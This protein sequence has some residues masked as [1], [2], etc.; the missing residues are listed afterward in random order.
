[1]EQEINT[2]SQKSFIKRFWWL[3]PII[4]V[5][6]IAAVIFLS[7]KIK[8]DGGSNSKFFLDISQKVSALDSR[9]VDTFAV[10]SGSAFQ[11]NSP[12][13]VDDYIYIGS[14]RRVPADT[15]PE[16]LQGL[17]HQDYFYK[18]DLD[19]NEIWE[20]ALPEYTMCGGGAALDSDG[21]IYFVATR[22]YPDTRP[23]NEKS[24]SKGIL[25]ENWIYS[26]TNSG[27]FRW[28]KL[29]SYPNEAWL[30]AMF[31]VSISDTDTIYVADSKLFAFNQN[32]ETNWQYPDDNRTI[33]GNRSAAIIDD[34]GYIYFIS[35]DA[36]ENYYETDDIRLFKFAPN[37]NGTPIYSVTLD[38]NIMVESNGMGGGYKDRWQLSTPAFSTNKKTI[39]A[40]VGNTMNAINTSDGEILWSYMPEGI[41][42]TFKASP[43][44][45]ADNNIYV[46]TKDNEGSVFYAFKSDGSGLLW[47]KATSADLYVSP[48]IGDDNTIY[49]GSETSPDGQF[50]AIDMT[51]GEYKWG[52][53]ISDFSFSSPA[54]YNGYIY[55]GTF[56]PTEWGSLLKIKVDAN[57]YPADTAWPR[58]HGGNLNNGQ[59][60]K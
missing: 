1:M 30:H 58:F 38:N 6:V 3:I 10:T 2:P 21:N 18:L 50:H 11:Y 57:N 4:V 45:D 43:A 31:N 16:D 23:I 59:K 7:W 24:I 53:A 60:G 27:E 36:T 22:Y 48:L 17:L 32:G 12:T 26:L 49:T 46:G 9:I 34:A 56:Q 42:G 14:S 13:I 39:F 41:T 40:A 5:V 37:S 44:V 29:I 19:L 55:I 52:F 33:S 28:K 51:T 47:K 20:Y 25:T 15:K 54:L 8:D 35:P